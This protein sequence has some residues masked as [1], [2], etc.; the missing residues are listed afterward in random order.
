[1]LYLLE[2]RLRDLS[3]NSHILLI[4]SSNF[5][6]PFSKCDILFLNR[7]LI[8]VTFKIKDQEF[9]I[10]IQLIPRNLYDKTIVISISRSGLLKSGARFIIERSEIK[11]T[12]HDFKCVHFECRMVL[13]Y[14]IW[15]KSRLFFHRV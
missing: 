9:H 15:K 2:N 13:F 11:K 8:G 5:L 14:T 1:M 4:I 10:R 6:Q 7:W 3:R 12:Q